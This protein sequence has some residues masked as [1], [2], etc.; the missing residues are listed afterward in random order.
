MTHDSE[1]TTIEIPIGDAHFLRG[2]LE[3][4]VALNERYGRDTSDHIR[5]IL[6][7]LKAAGIVEPE[8]TRA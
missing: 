1:K 3:Q 5:S 2:Y 7:A 4:S 6:Q 8:V